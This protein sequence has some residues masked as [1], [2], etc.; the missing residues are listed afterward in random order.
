MINNLPIFEIKQAFLDALAAKGQVVISA[1][2]GSG[3]STQIP[4]FLLEAVPKDQRILVL[5]PRRLATRMLAERI[6]AEMDTK[7]GDVVGYQTRYERVAS[8][9]TR[10]L[11]ITEGILTRMLIS[12]RNLPG[13]GAIVFDE[14]HE[15]S[16][17]TDL[18]LAMAA[19]VRKRNRP[20][21]KLVVMSATL[22]AAPICDYLGDCPHLHAE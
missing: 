17:N 8:Q 6:A 9:E 15:R 11:F 21:L 2:T 12:N 13:V 18:G 4:K 7:I 20:D 10:I 14:F 3:K 1:P 22:D 16:I 19:Y 5:Q